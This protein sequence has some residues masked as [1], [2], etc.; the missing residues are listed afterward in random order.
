MV[1]GSETN[2]EQS[3]NIGF[4]ASTTNIALNIIIFFLGAIVIYLMYSIFIKINGNEVVANSEKGGPPSEI[5]QVEVLNGCGI[6]GVAD[7]F[8]DYLRNNGFDVVNV[9][10][11]S[12]FDMPKTTVI[13]R[14]GN[15]A[16]AEKTA[17]IL[18]VSKVNVTQNQNDQYFVDVTV[19]IGKDCYVLNPL[20]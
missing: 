16:N 18:G 17:K 11:Y 13:D 3:G 19:V 2:K 4:K 14:M 8:T 5:I 20:K 6:A 12:S 10:N 1:K 15:M 9:R 7:R